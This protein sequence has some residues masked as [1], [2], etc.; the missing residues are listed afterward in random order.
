MKKF[1]T[2][3]LLIVTLTMLFNVPVFAAE[4]HYPRYPHSDQAR[5]S[6]DTDQEF[7]EWEERLSERGTAHWYKGHNVLITWYIKS[8]DNH[9]NVFARHLPNKAEVYALH[10]DR[11]DF[12]EF[13]K[14]YQAESEDEIETVKK[15]FEKEPVES[16]IGFIFPVEACETESLEK[17][18][19][20]LRNEIVEKKIPIYWNVKTMTWDPNFY[21]IEVAIGKYVIQQGDTLSQIAEQFDTSVE[22]IMENNKNIKN[23]DL[24]YAGNYLCIW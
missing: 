1:A 6:T 13:G 22:E 16:A 9:Q 18:T 3:A 24:I 19:A 20:D 12:I 17:Y 14:L 5:W 15:A 21:V 4:S 7:K 8:L 23:P 11:I 10:T 2:L